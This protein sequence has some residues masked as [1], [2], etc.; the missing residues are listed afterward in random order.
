MDRKTLV[1]SISVCFSFSSTSW[2]KQG[3]TGKNTAY[4][5]DRENT[6]NFEIS[7]EYRENT[8]NFAQLIIFYMVMFDFLAPSAHLISKYVDLNFK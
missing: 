4:F 2:E 1:S 5:S 8:G 3:E 7:P 6:G